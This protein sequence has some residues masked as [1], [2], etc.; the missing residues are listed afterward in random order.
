VPALWR[1]YVG[2]VRAGVRELVSCEMGLQVPPLGTEETRSLRSALG[3]HP[4][5]PLASGGRLLSDV[6]LKQQVQEPT[7]GLE[8]RLA[9]GK[10]PYPAAAPG[11]RV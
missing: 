6:K 9:P 3:S 2:L 4:A 10:R 11:G 7:L 5:V 8:G 1:V